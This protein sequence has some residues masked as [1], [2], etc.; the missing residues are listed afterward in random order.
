[1]DRGGVRKV[2][3][4]SRLLKSIP[5]EAALRGGLIRVGKEFKT[6]R[7][8]IGEHMGLNFRELGTKRSELIA[9]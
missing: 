6:S 7:V 9:G 1:M 8:R 2:G 4:S 5:R 3:C